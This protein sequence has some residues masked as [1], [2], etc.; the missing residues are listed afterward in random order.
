MNHHPDLHLPRPP[1]AML[2]AS[3]LFL[4]FDG[5]LVDIAS[6]PEEV[7][8]SRDLLPLLRRLLTLL[9]GRMAIVSGRELA[10][11]ARQLHPLEIAIA[12]SHGQEIRLAGDASPLVERPAG[13]DGAIARLR[14]LEC[15]YPGVQLEE[16]ALGVAVHYRLAAAAEE[17]CRSAVANAAE[18]HGFDVQRG[19]MVVELKPPGADKGAALRQ[20]MALAPF[21]GTTPLF[22]GDDLTDEHGFQA[23]AALG[24]AGVLVGDQRPT[25]ALYRL[26]SVADALAWLDTAAGEIE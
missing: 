3:S 2:R 9:D 16:K 8:V 10:G 6:R 20:L 25:A 14:E 13:L 5:T 22:F 17:A 26:P 12:G 1:A 4:D 21:A 23:A 24:G 18:L 11:V 15:A 7:V 19:K